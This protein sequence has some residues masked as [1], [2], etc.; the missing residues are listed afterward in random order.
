MLIV[1]FMKLC[2]VSWHLYQDMY[3]IVSKCIIAALIRLFLT[4]SFVSFNIMTC[5]GILLWRDC[6][7]CPTL[8]FQLMLSG[9]IKRLWSVHWRWDLL[10]P[11][12][13][14]IN[15][16]S[17]WAMLAFCI[18]RFWSYNSCFDWLWSHFV[19]KSKDV[20]FFFSIPKYDI[21][22]LSIVDWAW[23]QCASKSCR[24]SICHVW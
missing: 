7:W 21:L 19:W 17:F 18:I 9:N 2:I 13:Y 24:S 14:N 4:A 22:F 11:G 20:C 3:H 8:S 15:I 12:L 16:R 23:C 1:S 10:N 6:V 5:P